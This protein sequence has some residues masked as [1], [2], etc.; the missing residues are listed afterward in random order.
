MS[1]FGLIV[2][3][4]IAIVVMILAIS[5]WKLHPFLAIMGISLILSLVV[6]IPLKDIPGLIGGAFSWYFP[7]QSVLLL[8]SELLSGQYWKRRELH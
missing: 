4:I 3:F 6:G 5:K 8:F 2:T 1:G 7:S